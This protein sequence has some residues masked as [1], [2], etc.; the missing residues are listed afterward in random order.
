MAPMLRIHLFATTQSTHRAP[1]LFGIAK[2][3]CKDIGGTQP[4]QPK[5]A[6]LRRMVRT[7]IRVKCQTQNTL[8][9]LSPMHYEDV[10]P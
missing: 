5:Q 10:A 9:P 3:E 2:G 6:E 1:L 4:A 7:E 8:A